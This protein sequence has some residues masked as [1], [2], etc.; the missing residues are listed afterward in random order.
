MITRIL[1][2]KAQHWILAYISYISIILFIWTERYLIGVEFIRIWKIYKLP[3]NK[4]WRTILI[5]VKII[6]IYGE[7]LHIFPNLLLNL[8]YTCL[9]ILGILLQ[10]YALQFSYPKHFLQPL[11][12]LSEFSNNLIN[13]AF[14][15]NWLVFYFFSLISIS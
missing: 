5:I 9:N 14:V 2:F 11:V 3:F 7:W 1:N 8:K 6:R 12:L 15:Y 4:H 13:C 10:I